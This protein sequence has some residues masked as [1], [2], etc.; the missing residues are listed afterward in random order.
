MD[1]SLK[2][3]EIINHKNALRALGLILFS[4][5]L[6]R[7]IVGVGYVNTMDVYWYRSWAVDL[8]NGLFGVY[9]RAEEITLDYP[10]IYLYFLY[11]LGLIYKHTGTEIGTFFNMLIM[12]FWPIVFDV[13]CSLLLYIICK[14]YG[15]HI[16]LFAA[17]AWALNPS[18]LF[19]SSMWGQ[20]DEMMAFL[21]LLAF[22]LLEED[23]PVASCV[24]FAVAGLTKYQSLVFTPVLLLEILSRYDIKRFFKGIGAA[25][26][27]VFSV[28]LPFMAGARNP[29]LF[30]DVYFGGSGKYPYCTLNAFNVYGIFKLNYSDRISENINFIGPISAHSF[31][32]FMVVMVL[33]LL[34]L[35]Y[36]YH[37][38]TGK[39][40]SP[41][42]AC[43]IIMQWV[44]MF[45]TRMHERYQ[46]I[47]LP[48][49]L[50]A[51]I[52]HRYKGFL[53]LYIA[54]T[55]MTLLNQAYLLFYMNNRNIFYADYYLEGLSA[56]SFANLLLFA[57]S[58]VECI[59][60]YFPQFSVESVMNIF[61]K[62]KEA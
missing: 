16:G 10:P 13:L 25:A 51:Y 55:I 17:S 58:V 27:T 22:W 36:A 47:V 6:L 15:R 18:T 56:F 1:E 23:R 3:N 8:P 34:L 32:V 4:S 7:L 53:R 44:F 43:F 33:V 60:F 41:W 26:A 49:L 28:F 20:T 46:I 19:N 57:W 48:F 35:L 29:L 21:L 14:R 12:K 62:P 9:A 11:P 5:L 31:G 42:V 59:K 54:L 52:A 38:K 40:G 24:A 37:A 50:M 61:K 2:L 45:A 30:F 39:P